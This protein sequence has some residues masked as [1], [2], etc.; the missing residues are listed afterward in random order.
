MIPTFGDNSEKSQKNNVIPTFGDDTQNF[1]YR[2]RSNYISSLTFFNFKRM[3]VRIKD[4]KPTRLS[5]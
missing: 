3:V 5:V 1:L 2:N 4:C